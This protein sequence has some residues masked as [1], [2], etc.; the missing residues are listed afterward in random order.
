MKSQKYLAN[1]FRSPEDESDHLLALCHH[2]QVK[3]FGFN[4]NV[5]LLIFLSDPKPSTQNVIALLLYTYNTYW[6]GITE[7]KNKDG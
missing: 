1:F 4:L 7:I 5:A 3:T 2:H 6:I